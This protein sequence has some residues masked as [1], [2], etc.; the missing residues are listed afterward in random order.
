[1]IKK[2]WVRKHI[3][4]GLT[5]ASTKNEVEVVYWDASD[6]EWSKILKGKII[7]QKK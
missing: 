4:W 6:K 5:E 2:F 3:I 1:M 7:K